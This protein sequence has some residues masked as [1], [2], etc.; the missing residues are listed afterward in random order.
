MKKKQ[1]RRRRRVRRNMYVT[2]NYICIYSCQSRIPFLVLPLYFLQTIFSLLLPRFSS[3]L[4]LPL[5]DLFHFP[6]HITTSC[7]INSLNGLYNSC[8]LNSSFIENG[9]RNIR[10]QKDEKKK[11]GFLY[12]LS[13]LLFFRPFFT[14]LHPNKED[15]FT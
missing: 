13:S 1:R 15:I 6:P 11:T 9:I 12:Y 2:I 7:A 4:F 14:K 10:R 8:P 3:Y 5:F